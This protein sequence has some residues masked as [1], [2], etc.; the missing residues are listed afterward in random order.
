MSTRKNLDRTLRANTGGFIHRHRHASLLFVVLLG[1]C[2][3]FVDVQAE[4]DA[5][6]QQALRYLLKQD[7]GACHGMRLSGGLGPPLQPQTLREKSD[8]FLLDTILNGRPDTPMPP[9][10]GMLSVEEARWLIDVLRS[11]EAL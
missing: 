5:P 4:P 7:C 1:L 3:V 10:A 9:W 11:G 6:R 8:A 2:V